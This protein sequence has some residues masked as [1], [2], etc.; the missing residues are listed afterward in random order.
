[1]T[2]PGHTLCS[3]HPPS[4]HT[5]THWSQETL[6]HWDTSEAYSGAH[7]ERLINRHKSIQSLYHGD[8]NSRKQS[9]SF[10]HNHTSWESQR[11]THKGEDAEVHTLKTNKSIV[12]RPVQG[13]LG[14]WCLPLVVMWGEKTVQHGQVTSHQ[15][16]TDFGVS[17]MQF[18]RFY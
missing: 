18:F 8:T 5:Q 2:I 7:E 10:T 13:R 11:Q 17:C 3:V 15:K 14:S 1:M 12:A 16:N 9:S 4:A 6:H